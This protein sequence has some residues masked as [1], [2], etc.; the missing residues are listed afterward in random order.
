MR[1]LF[2]QAKSRGLH[3]MYSIQCTIRE[4]GCLLYVH[5]EGRGDYPTVGVSGP[6]AVIGY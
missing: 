1:L 6:Q 3:C 4:Q 2:V 5:G